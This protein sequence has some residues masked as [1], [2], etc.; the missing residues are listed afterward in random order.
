MAR[1][2]DADPA[3]KDLPH[4]EKVSK[5]PGLYDPAVENFDTA[6]GSR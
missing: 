6:Q 1:E 3:F 2:A 4:P 5:V